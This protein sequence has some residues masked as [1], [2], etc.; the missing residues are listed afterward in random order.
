MLEKK[1][2]VKKSGK[3]TPET[4]GYAAYAFIVEHPAL[5]VSGEG[6]RAYCPAQQMLDFLYASK[7][8][9][10]AA[11]HDRDRDI[12]GKPKPEHFHVMVLFD[13]D[14]E[15]FPVCELFQ[16]MEGAHN[17]QPVTSAHMYARYLCHL[18]NPDKV[19]YC[20]DEVIWRGHNYQEFIK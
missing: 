1:E 11:F 7:L 8:P 5:Y 13:E 19:R 18:D 12:F 2:G 15:A 9:F 14:R 16:A 17:L 6:G 3:V 20:P 10:F 4:K